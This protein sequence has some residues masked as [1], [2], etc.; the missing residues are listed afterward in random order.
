[1]AESRLSAFLPAAVGGG[2]E[3]AEIENRIVYVRAC[4]EA[5]RVFDGASAVKLLLHSQRA[6]VCR[7][8]CLPCNVERLFASDKHALRA[9]GCPL[10]AQLITATRTL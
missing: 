2:T 10:G 8:T 1:M 6:M 5:L 9:D 3:A 4:A 7:T